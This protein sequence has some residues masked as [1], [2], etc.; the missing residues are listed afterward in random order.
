MNSQHNPFEYDAAN[1]LPSDVLLDVYVEDF[2]YSRFIQ[3]R[4][5]IFLVGER[6]SGKTTTLLYNS[7]EIQLKKS[8]KHGQAHSLELI[9]VYIPC[10]TPITHKSEY[11]LLPDFNAQTISEHF[12]VLTVIH[13]IARTL[14]LV[15]KIT[16][17]DVDQ[18]ALRSEFEYLL[19]FQ[20]R[21]SVNLF[22][23]LCDFAQKE[24]IETQRK[25]NDPESDA[26]YRN[27]LTFA[28]GV[29][30]VL[31]LIRRIPAL[32]QSH[33]SLM[34]D[35]AHDLNKYQS[36]SLNS[37][38]AYRDHSHFSFK[39]AT[40]KIGQANFRTTTGAAILEGHDFTTVDM[41]QPLQ[42]ATSDY[43][44]MATQVIEKRLVRS[45]IVCSAR[46]FFPISR[47]FEI[48]MQS[49]HERVKARV[50]SE[51]KEWT[52]KQISDYVYKFGRAEYFRKR[53]PRANRPE[54]SGFDTIVYLSTG[55]IRNLL[56][57]C[58]KMYEAAQ[59][60]SDFRPGSSKIDA[61][62]AGDQ[63]DI[64]LT[65]SQSM[66]Q[67][68][69]TGLD[70]SIDG[71]SSTQANQ[72]VTLFEKLATY[73]RERL[74][75]HESEPQANS[76]SLTGDGSQEWGDL[77]PLLEIAR[78]AQLLYERI[79]PAKAGGL[80]EV[81]YV[82]NRMLW[83]SIGLDL[84]GQHARASLKAKDLLAAANGSDIPMKAE[85][86]NDQLDLFS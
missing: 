53:S 14:T 73:F 85:I 3:S 21:D 79:G 41:E 59:S 39:V 69:K 55:V 38:I 58:H 66:W 2:N 44:R 4:K 7:L 10:N 28:S 83:P 70:R 8:Q 23:G 9:G 34:L 77:M 26:T 11:Q 36:Q 72:V 56:V 74:L 62:S 16:L 29:M 27:C 25:I 37:W 13:Q 57:P 84:H 33:F 61:I 30:P 64:I 17:D 86:V 60:R 46:E 12:L 82:P 48:E 32:T 80:R 52:S 20:I 35:D 45:G 43:G 5:N 76:F 81:Y 71:C 49:C 18:A 22:D 75:K 24:I 40:A 31:S 63:A 42:T 47:T 67:R 6:G 19:G 68:L 1:N 15:A 54:Y 50:T 78:K 51:H 65:L